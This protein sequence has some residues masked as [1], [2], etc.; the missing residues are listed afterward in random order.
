ML[1]FNHDILNRVVAKALED[2]K[3][4]PK[5]VNAIKKA[6]TAML[7]NPYIEAIDNHTLLIAGESGVYTGNSSCQCTAYLKGK[8]CYHRSMA[9]LWQRYNEALARQEV[10]QRQKQAQAAIDELFVK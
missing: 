4:Y 6:H 1:T 2:A 7:E 10:T 3:G 9:R 5:W 8:P